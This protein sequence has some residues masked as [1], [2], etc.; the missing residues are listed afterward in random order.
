MKGSPSSRWA[1]IMSNSELDKCNEMLDDEN[2]LA[3]AL[4]A[5][6]HPSR[7]GIIKQLVLR[8]RCCGGDFCNCLPLSQS[9]ISQHLDQLKQAGIVDWQQQGTRSIY[10]LNKERLLSLSNDLKA[11]AQSERCLTSSNGKKHKSNLAENS[12]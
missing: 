3:D 10:T 4:R 11:L 2:D 9:T 12:E 7:L 5:L 6:A 8:D 1:N